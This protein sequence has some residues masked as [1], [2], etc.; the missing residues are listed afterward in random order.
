MIFFQISTLSFLNGPV[1]TILRQWRVQFKICFLYSI[2]PP[3]H[4]CNCISQCYRSFQFSLFAV[5]P[6]HTENCPKY[7]CKKWNKTAFNPF[8]AMFP[9]R[10]CKMGTLAWVKG[11]CGICD[12][13][14]EWSVVLHF[15]KTL[16]TEIYFD[17]FYF[18]RDLS[19]GN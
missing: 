14:R 7:L 12:G 9:V 16:G 5:K 10:G 6:L 2:L 8:L 11:W 19:S 17:I 15:Y 13:A 3:K 4:H 18:I 1:T